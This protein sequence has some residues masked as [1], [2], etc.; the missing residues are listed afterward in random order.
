[1]LEESLPRIKFESSLSRKKLTYP[2]GGKLI[3][4]V[5]VNVEYWSI[6]KPMPRRLLTPPGGNSSISDIPNWSWHE[7]GWRSGMPRIFEVL[8]EHNIRPTASINGYVCKAYPEMAQLMA[9]LSWDFMGHGYIQT[10]MSHVENEQEVIQETKS[11][12]ESFTNK[13]MRGWMGPG[14]VESNKTANLLKKLGVEWTCDWVLDDVP[15]S[16]ET[17]YGTLIGV[18]YSLEFNDLV[19]NLVEQ[20]SSDEVYRRVMDSLPIYL[21][22]CN[23]EARVLALPLHPYISGVPH[24]IKWLKKLLDE[25]CQL[26]EVTFMTGSEIADWYNNQEVTRT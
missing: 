8:Q 18:P 2:P 24:R 11:I 23:R 16:I 4:H 25:L 14:L 26:P 17:L 6:D 19:V 22:E 12:I 1:M 5:I 20:R 9:D 21:E 3:V 15:T 10:P 13:P 7:Y